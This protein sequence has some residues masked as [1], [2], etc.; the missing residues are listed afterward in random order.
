MKIGQDP[1]LEGDRQSKLTE[2][3]TKARYA[4]MT[5]L[6]NDRIELT[7]YLDVMGR[8]HLIDNSRGAP[9]IE[10][11]KIEH[12]KKYQEKLVKE[13]GKERQEQIKS[14]TYKPIQKSFKGYLTGEPKFKRKKI[15][16]TEPIAKHKSVPP[17]KATQTNKDEGNKM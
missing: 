17:K 16:P 10:K 13:K 14:N 8:T 2:M 11:K 3:R 15:E 12:A 6:A 9:K 4:I 5:K 7:T 1:R